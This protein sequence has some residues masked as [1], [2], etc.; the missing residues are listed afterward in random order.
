MDKLDTVGKR[1]RHAI[2]SAGYDRRTFSAMLRVDYDT[3]GRWIRENRIPTN[4]LRRSRV[5][6]VL[7]IRM[8]WI[9]NGIEPKF[10]PQTRDVQSDVQAIPPEKVVGIAYKGTDERSGDDD[11]TVTTMDLHAYLSDLVD[12]QVDE[13]MAM[14]IIQEGGDVQFTVTE[15]LKRVAGVRCRIKLI[16]VIE[17]IGEIAPLKDDKGLPAKSE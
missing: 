15:L 3:V 14:E 11:K 10:V 6:T 7:G 16:A 1:L 8:E 4:A 12:S 13:D 5:E 2:K 17:R 9:E